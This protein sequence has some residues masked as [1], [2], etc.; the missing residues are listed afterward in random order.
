MARRKGGHMAVNMGP[1][2][3]RHREKGGK[4]KTKS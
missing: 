2:S 4:I 1:T 3:G